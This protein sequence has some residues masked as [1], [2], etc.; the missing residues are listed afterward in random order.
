M[1]TR[2]TTELI[3]DDGLRVYDVDVHSTTGLWAVAGPDNFNLSK[4]DPDDLPPGFRWVDAEEWSR[5][6]EERADELSS[7]ND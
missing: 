4:F 6:C 7:R 3:T 2:R 1:T 5:L